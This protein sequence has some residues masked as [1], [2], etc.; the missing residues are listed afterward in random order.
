MCVT[1]PSHVFLVLKFSYID[2]RGRCHDLKTNRK[3]TFWRVSNVIS[4]ETTVTVNLRP[5]WIWMKMILKYRNEIQQSLSY[6][7]IHVYMVFLVYNNSLTMARNICECTVLF[8]NVLSDQFYLCC[9]CIKLYISYPYYIFFLHLSHVSIPIFNSL[10]VGHNSVH[11]MSCYVFCCPLCY[12]TCIALCYSTF[13]LCWMKEYATSILM[14]V[15][16]A[17]RDLTPY[18]P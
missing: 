4:Y 18:F 17:I 16:M 12:C 8:R 9:F 1:H 15:T 7:E 6:H 14:G 13:L 11:M 2:V 5:N 3:R 10:C